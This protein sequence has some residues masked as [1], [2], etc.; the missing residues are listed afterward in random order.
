VTQQGGLGLGL[1]VFKGVIEEHG[2][3]VAASSDGP[4]FGAEFLFRLP[5]KPPPAT[6]PRPEVAGKHRRRR[7][8]V[9][10]D[11]RDS[12]QALTEMLRLQGHEVSAAPDGMIG[13]ELAR[14]ATPGNL[15]AVICDLGLPVMDGYEVVKALRR[16]PRISSLLVIALSGYGDEE[17]VARAFD[18]GFD[19]HLTKPV[20][21]ERL[22]NLLARSAEPADSGKAGGTSGPA[23]TGFKAES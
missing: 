3:T 13:L 6:A 9:I 11:H 14:R 8:L 19:H 23:R 15:D 17:A 2:G 20:D 22:R 12:V 7:I 5:R 1:A 4:G 10:D 21:L 18:A 16:D